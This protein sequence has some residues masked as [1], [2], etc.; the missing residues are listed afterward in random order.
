MALRA[1]GTGNARFFR[2]ATVLA[3]AVLLVSGCEGLGEDDSSAG[4]GRAA[5]AG[6][7]VSP[8]KNPDGTKPG[9][10]PLT[11][12]VDKA[13]ARNLIEE[14]STK[15]RGPK[16]GYDRDEFGYA[17]MDTA[18]GV[19]LARNGCDTRNDLLKR[20]GQSIRFRAGSDCVVVSMKLHDPYTGKDIAWKK[21]K[22][23]EVQVDHVV[24][25]SYAWQMGAARWDEE[26]RQRVANDALNLLPVSGSTNSAK[27]DSGPASW[28]PPSKAIRCSYSARFA[29]VALKYELPVTAADKNMMLQQCG[30]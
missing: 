4:S 18:D 3:T 27:R 20:D 7:A 17:W 10:A 12:D 16:T 21:A 22:A 28:L 29:Q 5:Q 11:T 2:A 24:P 8:L 1:G 23:T 30:A 6:Q 13:A 25:L 14:L 26:K 15:G 19:P 9:L